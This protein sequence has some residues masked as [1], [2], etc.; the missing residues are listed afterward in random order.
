MTPYRHSVPMAT[1]LSGDD[2]LCIFNLLEN[3][4]DLRSLCCCCKLFNELIQPRLFYRIDL[5]VFKYPEEEKSISFGAFR[6][7]L[8]HSPYLAHYPREVGIKLG[9]RG[10]EDVPYVLT[11]LTGKNVSVITL[12]TDR[13]NWSSAAVKS[14]VEAL[15]RDTIIPLNINLSGLPGLSASCLHFTEHAILFECVID[16][17]GTQDLCRTKTIT[18][19]G[20]ARCTSLGLL[21]SNDLPCLTHLMLWWDEPSGEPV[22]W[23]AELGTALSNLPK[24]VLLTVQYWGKNTDSSSCLST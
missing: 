4:K 8:E 3:D 6:Q 7:L 22:E 18:M 14:A 5:T 9:I 23:Y 21:V 13:C 20:F 1:K 11:A 15:F 19:A 2:L 12:T 16:S 24:L 17:A 10:T